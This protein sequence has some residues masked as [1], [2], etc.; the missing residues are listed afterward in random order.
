MDKPFDPELMKKT[1]C[2]GLKKLEQCNVS[3]IAIACNTIHIYDFLKKCINIP[4][5]NIVETTLNKIPKNTKKD[6][7]TFFL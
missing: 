4:L 3:F 7:A 2:E 1:V 5:L 6:K